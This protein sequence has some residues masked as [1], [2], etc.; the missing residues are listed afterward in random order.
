MKVTGS[1]STR[2]ARR[3]G[4]AAFALAVL[5]A[6]LSAGGCGGDESPAGPDGPGGEPTACF[7]I[8]PNPG[9]AGTSFLF[10]ARCSAGDTD[11]TLAFRWDF[12]GD[13]TFETSLG[14]LG[15][16]QR[17]FPDVGTYLV[18]LEVHDSADGLADTASATLEV[19][20]PNLPPGLTRLTSDSF[21]DGSPAWSLDGGSIAFHSNRSGNL[22]LWVID[23]AGR[24][25]PEQLTSAPEA[26]TQPAWSYDGTR[27]A[28]QSTREDPSGDIWILDVATGDAVR[29]TTVEGVEEHPTW[30]PD[31]LWIAYSSDGGG[32]G[33]RDIWKIPSAGGTAVQVTTEATFEAD[34]AWSPN[35]GAIAYQRRAGARWEIHRIAPDGGGTAPVTSADVVGFVGHPTWSSDSG[36]LAFQSNA[37]AD[38]YRVAAAGG[39]VANLT[40]DPAVAKEPAW[41][42]DG[43]RIAFVSTRGGS[44]DLWVLE[45]R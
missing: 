41:S 6:A 20:P 27:I 18:A 28:F 25:E 44:E 3:T 16:T 12:D 13:G 37:Q 7:T 8:A 42:P 19:T 5:F 23:F 1:V 40:N 39:D 35:G 43:A 36:S 29:L 24:A 15:F 2:A 31:G 14:S 34:P 17:V 9:D 38:V 45:L 26:D 22:D 21:V 33:T 11:S 10:D 32:T 4:R 30:S